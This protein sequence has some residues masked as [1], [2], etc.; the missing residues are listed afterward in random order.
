MNIKRIQKSGN[1]SIISNEILKRKDL[2]L[3]SKGLLT[4]ILSLPDKWELSVNGLVAIVKESKNTIYSILKELNGFGYVE[5]KR[6][7][8]SSGKVIKWELVVYEEP[9]TKKPDTKKPD[10]EKCTQIKTNTKLITKRIK[11][12]K[13]SFGILVFENGTLGKIESENFIDYWSET[14]SQGKMK[15][16]L[17]KTWDLNLRMKR[18]GRSRF[19]NNQNKGVSK[20]HQQI[21]SSENALQILNKMQ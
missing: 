17:Q 21:A 20:I 16:Q 13:E 18:W 12:T 9:L 7:T 4:L 19:G 1:Y 15:W 14:N 3:K 2:S 11:H 5:R 8:D 6:I 10:V